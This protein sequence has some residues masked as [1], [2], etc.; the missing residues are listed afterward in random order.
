MTEF[1]RAQAAYCLCTAGKKSISPLCPKGVSSGTAA[2]GVTVA[3]VVAV[4]VG[5]AV[6]VADGVGVGGMG[7]LTCPPNGVGVTVGAGCVGVMVG[8]S[9]GGA[10]GVTVAVG[11]GLAVGVTVGVGVGGAVLSMISTMPPA[12]LP[13]IFLPN[14][15]LKLGGGLDENST[16]TRTMPATSGAQ[17]AVKRRIANGPSG[18]C[19]NGKLKSRTMT[20]ISPSPSAA[21]NDADTLN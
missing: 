8:A 14:G 13:S 19:E 2:G 21:S 10:F 5:V 12:M 17:V 1:Q 3:K 4:A 20:S 9:G 11:D 18:N 16:G 7:G 15:L 6:G